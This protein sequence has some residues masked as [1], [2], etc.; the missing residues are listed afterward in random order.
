M[1]FLVRPPIILLRI[2]VLIPFQR[3][4]LPYRNKIPVS[5][6]YNLHAVAGS[7]CYSLLNA[8]H[9]GGDYVWYFPLLW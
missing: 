2:S 9:D 5:R 7:V 3:R 8:V 4:S 6:F 1:G